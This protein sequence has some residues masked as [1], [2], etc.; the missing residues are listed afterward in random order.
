MSVG[1]IPEY[2]SDIRFR[3]N[4]KTITCPRFVTVNGQLVSRYYEIQEGDRIEILE[5]YTLEQ[6][7][8]FMDIVCRGRVYVNNA[9][10]GMDTKVYDNFSIAC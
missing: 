1:D 5:Y 7:L 2:H 10:A 4:N 9:I 6:V 8:E 3:F